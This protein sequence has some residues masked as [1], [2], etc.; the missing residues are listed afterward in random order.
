MN[1]SNLED[2]LTNNT[3][4]RCINPLQSETIS[5][6]NDNSGSSFMTTTTTE[7]VTNNCINTPTTTSI[8]PRPI[9]VSAFSF[10]SG[11]EVSPFSNHSF[12]FG[13]E[14]VPN[15][16]LTNNI[17]NN[18]TS[19]ATTTTAMATNTSMNPMIV[20]E[21][22][23]G[24]DDE[25]IS[26]DHHFTPIHS[27]AVV[28]R[29]S[30]TT[31]MMNHFTQRQQAFNLAIQ[32]QENRLV[33]NEMENNNNNDSNFPNAYQYDIFSFEEVGDDDVFLNDNENIDD[34]HHQHQELMIE[35]EWYQPIRPSCS[36]AL[37]YD[38]DNNNNNEEYQVQMEHIEREPNLSITTSSSTSRCSST[39][40]PIPGAS[41]YGRHR[42]R[43]PQLMEN[44]DDI[45]ENFSNDFID[46]TSASHFMA[47]Q[48]EPEFSLPN[49]RRMP[50]FH[51]MAPR[52]NRSNVFNSLFDND[53]NDADNSAAS[54]INNNNNRPHQFGSRFQLSLSM[55]QGYRD[56]SECHSPPP[57]PTI[58]LNEI[59]MASGFSFRF[60]RQ[61]PNHFLINSQNSRNSQLFQSTINEIYA[62]QTLYGS[63]SLLSPII[64]MENDDDEHLQFPMSLDS[65]DVQQSSSSSL[66][67]E[68]IM[69]QLDTNESNEQIIRNDSLSSSSSNN[70][71]NRPSMD[72]DLVPLM[73]RRLNSCCQCRQH[74]NNN[75]VAANS[76]TTTRKSTIAPLPDVVLIPKL[77][78]NRSNKQ[79]HQRNTLLSFHE[80]PYHHHNDDS[81][82]HNHHH[83]HHHSNERRTMSVSLPID[84]EKISE[85][86]NELRQIS[87]KF[88]MLKIIIHHHH[89]TGN[90]SSSTIN[91][92]EQQQQQQT[93]NVAINMIRSMLEMITF[94]ST[95]SNNSSNQSTEQSSSSIFTVNNSTFYTGS[96]LN[97]S[98]SS[99]S[100][101]TKNCCKIG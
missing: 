4:N 26:I 43:S 1:N 80:V 94:L 61:S 19:T 17:N 52:L 47:E 39:P 5:S 10:D 66:R 12:P 9:S 49:G 90:G 83:H 27:P 79:H 62:N 65:N 82:S 41:T 11:F 63:R 78:T 45:N 81:F 99:S 2:F 57:L 37:M 51:R 28:N 36:M 64:E 97:Q 93:N 15:I 21:D 86:G 71:N 56:Q 34:H 50:Y 68:P 95:T 18:C 48:N 55:I 29:N 20:Q 96:S 87:H 35:R 22:Y 72:V 23:E 89:Q 32:R 58:P 31:Q 60:G 73:D 101:T 7:I 100:T 67:M 77:V 76:I 13:V 24:I 88:H 33:K 40:I 98:S 70:N 44:D 46:G 54:I 75:N 14:S 3:M 91:G 85:L 59:Q 53:N 6:I 8:R 84:F 30:S 38:D 74:N 69:E 92:N 16:I 42:Y 25:L